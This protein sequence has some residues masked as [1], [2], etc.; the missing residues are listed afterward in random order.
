MFFGQLR[1]MATK[2]FSAINYAATG[3]N[4]YTTFL[5]YYSKG[6]DDLGDFL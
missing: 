1:Q 3:A 6:K 2:E 4:A 5:C